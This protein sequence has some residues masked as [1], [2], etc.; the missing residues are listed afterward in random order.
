LVVQNKHLGLLLIW[1]EKPETFSE[2]DIRLTRLFADQAALALENAQ[3]LVENRQLAIEQERHRLARE[4][5]DSV[6]QSIYSIGLA[7]QA[8][9]RLLGEETAPFLKDTI[10]HIH[11]LSQRALFEIREQLFD[12]HPTTLDEDLVEVL[13]QHCHT[14][15]K[16]HDLDITFTANVEQLLSVHQK[17]ALYFIAREG[18]WNIIKHAR[19]NLVTLDLSEIGK[20]VVMTIEDNGVGFDPKTITY[21]GKMGLRNMHERAKSLGG[22][23]ELESKP[24]QGT[25]LTLWISVQTDL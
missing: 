5:H 19:A 24:G 1:S 14:L 11:T 12:L 2:A 6:T 18:L 21:T 10:G 25:K 20:K 13:T 22:R 8:S 23:F 3:L 7:A 15:R 17:N 16:Q 4:L 9:M